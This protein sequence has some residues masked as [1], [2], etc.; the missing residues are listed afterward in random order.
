MAIPMKFWEF[1]GRDGHLSTLNRPVAYVPQSY[2]SAKK[3]RGYNR[4]GQRHAKL[5]VPGG[6]FTDAGG[7][8]IHPQHHGDRGR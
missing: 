5:W 3:E 2:H 1:H 7:P 8:D 4:A 6:S